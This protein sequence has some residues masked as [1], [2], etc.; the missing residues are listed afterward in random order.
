MNKRAQ[1][2]AA[3]LDGS[4]NLRAFLRVIR[5]GESSQDDAAYRVQVFGRQ[6]DSLADHPRQVVNG[7]IGGKAVS[8]TAAGAYQF[9]ARTWDE[10]V[11]ALG[12][13]DFGPRSQD[14]A[15]VYLIER[16]RA[17]QDVLEG[18]FEAAIRKCNREWASLPGSPYGQPTMSLDRARAVYQQWGGTFD[19]DAV[20]TPT[21]SLDEEPAM[22]MPP[23]IAA[24]VPA[25]VELIPKLTRLFSSGS[26]TAERN[27]K[28]VELVAEVVQNATGARNIQEAVETMQSDP[29]A[30]AAA[31]RAVE[32]RWFDLVE[33]ASG[34]IEAARKADAAMVDR[35]G[36]WWQVARSPSFII[37]VLI[38][39]L[40]YMIVG[41]VVGLFGAPFDDDVRS[42]IAN[43]VIGM[44]LGGLIG[45]YYGQ[46]TSRNRAPSMPP[47]TDNR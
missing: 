15:A 2:L 29:E 46:T 31:T 39:P 17:L 21:E 25:L 20:S 16:R 26:P 3:I 41:A 1:R 43:G 36:P 27:V 35:E 45:Y 12:L 38:L 22:P 28:A 7:T 33:T 30:L 18:R 14:V 19:A 42:A 23:F 8:S 9:L 47:I 11:S 40:V 34:G 44:V 13:T 4:N 5:A 37:A 10:C 6:L 24:A 32:A